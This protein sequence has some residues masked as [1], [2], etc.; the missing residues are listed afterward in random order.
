MLYKPKS[1]EPT[2]KIREK[3]WRNSRGIQEILHPFVN[4][5]QQTGDQIINIAEYEQ[6][7]CTA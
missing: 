2:P 3:L 5:P 6:Y 1:Y 4:E 7:T